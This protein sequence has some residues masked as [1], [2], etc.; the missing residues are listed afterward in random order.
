MNSLLKTLLISVLTDKFFKE[1][2]VHMLEKLAKQSDNEVDDELVALVA[3]AL[4]VEKSK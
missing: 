1:L 2:V 3:T 4:S